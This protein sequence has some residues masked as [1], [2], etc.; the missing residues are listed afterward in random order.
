VSAPAALAVVLGVAKP[1]DAGRFGYGIPAGQRWRPD[2]SGAPD[3][4]A[5]EELDQGE[6]LE[7]ITNRLTYGARWIVDK[8]AGRYAHRD[9]PLLARRD[10]EALSIVVKY[11]GL[12]DA[13]GPDL[14]GLRRA[15]RDGPAGLRAYA[16]DCAYSPLARELARELADVLERAGTPPLVL[17]LA[18]PRA[19]RR[20]LFRLFRSLLL[21]P[22]STAPTA[23]PPVL[24][25]GSHG[26]SYSAPSIGRAPP[27]PRW[28]G[29]VS[30]SIGGEGATR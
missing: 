11:A 25:L 7:A 13:C 24:L 12:E 2:R 16:Q 28:R 14:A 8:A 20:I 27:R 23:A 21:R 22:R 19:A 9:G 4:N 18:A 29:E 26:S 10:L 1:V 17:L 30:L 15:L 5:L 6:E 3:L